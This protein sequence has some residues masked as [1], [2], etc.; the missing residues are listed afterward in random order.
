MPY[1]LNCVYLLA[2]LLTLPFW[3][4]KAL[5]TG[6]YREGLGRKL[7]GAPPKV[8]GSGPVVWLHAVSVGEVLLLGP[9]LARLRRRRPDWQLVV[10]TTTNTG[11]AVAREK[12]SDATVFYAPLD[13]TWAVRRVMDGLSPQLLVL[14]ELELWPN[15]LLEARRRRLPV[16]VINARLGERSYHGYRKLGT[17]L[18]PALAAVRWWGAQTDIYAE[19]IAELTT[20]AHTSIVVTGSMKY[21]GAPTDRANTK[22]QNLRQLLGFSTNER[23]F[24]AGS[25]QPGEEEIALSAFLQLQAEYPELRLILVPRQKDRFDAV[26]DWLR[27]QDTEH[28]RRSDIIQPRTA[29]APVTLVDTIGELSALWGLADYAFV[30]GSLTGARGGQSMIEPAGYGVPTCFGP[31]TWNFQDTVDKLLQARA[32]VQLQTAEDLLPTL[33]SWLTDPATADRLGEN[34]RQFILSQQGA[35]DATVAGIQSLLEQ[36]TSTSAAA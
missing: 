5:T 19:R 33:R 36:S 4:F 3:I 2:L 24:L 17:L 1:L 32:A 7:R 34:A 23:V 35:I 9:L 30:G 15:L 31:E 21:E 18:K 26:A 12:L 11:Y 25:T 13:F 6:K 20:G 8:A 29:S 22:T 28:V 27:R 10:S 16:A 14:A